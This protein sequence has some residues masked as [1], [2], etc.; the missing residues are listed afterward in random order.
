MDSNDFS[1]GNLYEF[2]KIIDLISCEH[3]I[4]ISHQVC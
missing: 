2:V 3:L 1:N 4:Q